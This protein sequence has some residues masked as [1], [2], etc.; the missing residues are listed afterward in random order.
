MFEGCHVITERSIEETQGNADSKG[1]HMT[2]DSIRSIKDYAKTPIPMNGMGSL[3]KIDEKKS[4]DGKT[5]IDAHSEKKMEHLSP[6]IYKRDLMG[7]SPTMTDIPDKRL[8]HRGGTNSPI[9][10]FD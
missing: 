4:E 10:I 5:D 1:Q 6:D 8:E 9:D 7:N 2:L 3:Y